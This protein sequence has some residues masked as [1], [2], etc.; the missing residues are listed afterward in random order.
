MKKIMWMTAAVIISTRLTGAELMKYTFSGIINNFESDTPAV[1][2]Q[3]FGITVGETAVTY[4]FAVD[5]NLNE[6]AVVNG[7]GRWDYFYS[8]L[9]SEPIISD[10]GPEA[11]E[12]YT[13]DYRV[14][15][16][17]SVLKGGST[18]SVL[19]TA[20]EHTQWKMQNWY[21]GQELSLTEEGSYDGENEARF[22][23]D[24]TLTSI[25]AI[26]EPSSG[27][28]VI[29]TGGVLGFLRRRSRR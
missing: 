17:K 12:S 24:V 25:E 23:A 22:Y 21:V 14:Y 19:A 20:D 3:D 2:A 4:A 16:D 26:P 28:L 9:L 13:A 10:G 8:D 15:T 7:I 18:V 1:T 5:F 29:A 11:N 27:I 6:R